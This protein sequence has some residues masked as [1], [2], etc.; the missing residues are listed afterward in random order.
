MLTSDRGR[1]SGFISM[2]LSAALSLGVILVLASTQAV[3]DYAQFAKGM[4]YGGLAA[5]LLGF[6]NDTILARLSTDERV[7]VRVVVCVR[8]LGFFGGAAIAGLVGLRF[9]A[10]FVIVSSAIMLHRFYFEMTSRQPLFNFWSLAEKI[11][12]IVALTAASLMT[13]GEDDV[14]LLVLA[15]AW[16]A[17]VAAGFSYF[18]LSKQPGHRACSVADGVF[19]IFSVGAP[20]F[21]SYLSVQVAAVIA[22]ERSLPSQI[23][24]YGTASQVGSALVTAVAFWQRP[25]IRRY[26]GSGVNLRSEAISAGAFTMLASSA[27]LIASHFFGDP[28]HLAKNYSVLWGFCAYALVYAVLHPLE[29][30]GYASGN[31]IPSRVLMAPLVTGALSIPSALMLGLWSAPFLMFVNT[32]VIVWSVRRRQNI[33][34][35]E[36]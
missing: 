10:G 12:L 9:L 3:E 16:K 14:A 19:S 25:V 27:A 35:S 20:F 29:L 21:M 33:N 15:V 31:I 32:A 18:V 26:F 13:S 6:G 1:L 34:G 4:I 22:S 8:A 2:A 24:D 28:F 23:A 17:G 30:A 11:G 5:V 36:S 7:D